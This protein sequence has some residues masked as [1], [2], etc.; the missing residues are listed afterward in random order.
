MHLCKA[1]QSDAGGQGPTQGSYPSA[2]VGSIPA[3]ASK[4][5]VSRDEPPKVFP[6]RGGTDKDERDESRRLTPA[7][8]QRRYREKHGNAYRERER[9]RMARKRDRV[10]SS[11]K[12]ASRKVQLTHDPPSPEE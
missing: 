4:R 7:E 6:N 5:E 11:A 2:Q 3:P 9:E 10:E 8:K 12:N 1:M